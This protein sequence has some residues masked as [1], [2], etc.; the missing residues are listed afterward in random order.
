MVFIKKK[1][2]LFVFIFICRYLTWILLDVYLGLGQ[3]V[4]SGRER[5]VG[6]SN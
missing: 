1:T 6:Q 2:L 3:S 5:S 4:S